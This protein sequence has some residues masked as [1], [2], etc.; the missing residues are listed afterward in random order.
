MALIMEIMKT[1]ADP[2][3]ELSVW[4]EETYNVDSSQIMSKWRELTG[5]NISITNGQ[6]SHDKVQ[7]LEVDSTTSPKSKKIPRTKDVC[8]HIFMGGQKVG[9]Q[10]ST[11]PKGG[12]SFCSAHR[13]KDSVTKSSKDKEIKSTKK[14]EKKE[15]KQSVIDPEFNSD[16]DGEKD[17]LMKATHKKTVSKK[18]VNNNTDVDSDGEIVYAQNSPKKEKP[19]RKKKNTVVVDDS[20]NE[21][22]EPKQSTKKDLDSED[23]PTTPV[24]PLLKKQIKS[25]GSSEAKLDKNIDLTDEE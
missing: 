3:A 6:V 1:I 23:E 21:V 24:K 7:S 19:S 11:K 9:E 8:Q 2:I 10:C 18:K 4:I 20:D 14:K 17:H 16:S 25:K 15:V 12:A 5:M 13:P 22:V